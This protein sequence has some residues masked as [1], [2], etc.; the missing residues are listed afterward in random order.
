MEER[1]LACRLNAGEIPVP[2]NTIYSDD[3]W[4]VD[5]GLAPDATT[6][7]ASLKGHMVI[8]ARRHV[9]HVYLL[10][11]EELLFFGLLL[12]DVAEAVA[13]AMRP[14]RVHVCSFGESVRHVH[15]HVIP[16]YAGMP[17]NPA[18]VL[19]GIF[20]L[21]LWTCRPDEAAKAAQE[22]KGFLDQLVAARDNS[23]LYAHPAWR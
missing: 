8:R 21:K 4:A 10:T 6:S 15:W 13:R 3:H 2:G 1:C 17:A 19:N 11:D 22:I 14:E 12:H 7:C 16:R 9:E 5:H 20:R 23:D 18:D